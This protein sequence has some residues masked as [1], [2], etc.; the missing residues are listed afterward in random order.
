MKKLLLFIIVIGIM[1]C[2]QKE[3]LTVQQIVDKAIEVSGGELYTTSE[4]SFDFRK[5]EYKLSYVSNRKQL[6]RIFEK[7]GAIVKDVLAANKLQRFVNDSLIQ[8]PDSM[9]VKYVNSVNSVHY[10][11]YLPYGLNDG[12][13]KKELLGEVIIKEQSYYKLKV[14]FAK[15]GGGVDYDDT[16]I[17][18]FN[19]ETFKPD[20]LA[21]E[22]H[23][24]KGGIRF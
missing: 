19:K 14:T 2:K 11:A 18:W 24:G 8:V 7:D 15:E 20:Y 3:K 21:Y 9:A 16:Y 23:V 10:F 17:Y 4:I 22:Y 12:A 13:V 5:I 6:K 1:S